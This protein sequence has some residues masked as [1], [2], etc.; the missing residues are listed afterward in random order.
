[1]LLGNGASARA[2]FAERRKLELAMQRLK[3]GLVNGGAV[4]YGLPDRVGTVGFADRWSTGGPAVAHW[5]ALAVA[6]CNPAAPDL[7]KGRLAEARLASE[8]AVAKAAAWRR[9]GAECSRQTCQDHL[10]IGPPAWRRLPE[11]RH[12]LCSSLI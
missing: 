12:F 1:M 5:P 2:A 4:H 7:L 8:G 9:D 11:L 10:G 6:G 3:K